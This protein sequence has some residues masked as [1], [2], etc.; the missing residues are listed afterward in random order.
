MWKTTVPAMLVGMLIAGV[1]SV[2][3]G[4]HPLAGNA[5]TSMTAPVRPGQDA[6][7][8]RSVLAG[9][10]EAPLTL[11]ALAARAVEGHYGHW[12]WSAPPKP[13]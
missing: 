2:V 12:G 11:C 6:A 4:T 9:A 1:G 7:W 8:A 13:T 5:A 3:A 10:R